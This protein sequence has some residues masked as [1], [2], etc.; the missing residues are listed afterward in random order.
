[1]TRTPRSSTLIGESFLPVL[2]VEKISQ[3]K[4]IGMLLIL[5]VIIAALPLTLNLAQQKQDIR[6]R[7]ADSTPTICSEIGTDTILIIDKSNSMNNPSSATDPLTRFARAKQ[8]AKNFA[9][10]LADKNASL[11]DEK[12]HKLGVVSFSNSELTEKNAELTTDMNLIKQQ[13]DAIQPGNAQTGWTC[14]ECGVKKANTE[15][16]SDR[17]RPQ[18]NNVAILLTDGKANWLD[19]GTTSVSQ[20]LAE[21]KALEA[22][23]SGFT[24]YQISYFTIG[25]GAQQEISEAFLKDIASKTNAKYYYAPTATDLEGIYTHISQ[26]IGKG[27]ISGFVFNDANANQTF[28]TT[29]QPLPNWSITLMQN[30]NI[31]ASSTT[32]INGSYT[33]ADVCDGNYSVKLSL[34]PGWNQTLPPNGNPITATLINAETITNQNFGV[35]QQPTRSTLSCSPSSLPLTQDGQ[36]VT[37]TLK[38]NNSVPL[39]GK[40]ITWTTEGGPITLTEKSSTTNTQ[41]ASVTNAFVPENT[42]AGFSGKIIAHFSGDLSNAPSSCEI[43]TQY[44]PTSTTLSLIVFLHGIGASGDNANPKISTL[45]NKNPMHTSKEMIVELYSIT[46]PNTLVVSRTVPLVYDH[47]S[48]NFKGSAD[49]GSHFPTGSYNILFKLNKYL[50]RRI[51]QTLTITKNTH[52]SLEPINLIA[53]DSDN[54][55][56]LNILD[57]DLIIGCYSDYA[58]P[59]SCTNAQKS[60]TDINDDGKVNQLDYNLFLRELSVQEGDTIVEKENDL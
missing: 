6:Q 44:T 5:L 60:A 56:V 10:I 2:Y 25:L 21:Q 41:G 35:K 8:A 37:A 38:D 11:P 14:I 13:I 32:D 42:E 30:N 52:R 17:Q 15:F 22:V 47:L 9:D 27:S 20:A 18:L 58:P 26:V 29:E 55:N 31:V 28:E 53:G 23:M 54:N 1:M 49:L 51:S 33:F 34:Q 43:T 36:L 16:S 45:S 24:T 57:Y 3:D 4:H 19:G 39:S 48:G 46:E 40:T 50:N 12:K 59:V 7:A